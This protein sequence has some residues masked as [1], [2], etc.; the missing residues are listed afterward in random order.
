MRGRFGHACLALMESLACCDWLPPLCSC[1]RSQGLQQFMLTLQLA[2]NG[3]QL[4]GQAELSCAFIPVALNGDRF[5]H[6]SH[7]EKHLRRAMIRPCVLCRRRQV[8]I[9][10]LMSHVYGDPAILA[11]VRAEVQQLL[12][13][14]AAVPVI[15]V[16]S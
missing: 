14:K 16:R 1:S 13:K 8:T 4:A 5:W 12:L 3:N 11:G 9:R 7:F 10:W 6:V 15:L 2:A